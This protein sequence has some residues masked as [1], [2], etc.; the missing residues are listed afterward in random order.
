[1]STTQHCAT[2]P[3]ALET[4]IPLAQKL[5]AREARTSSDADDLVQVALF[6]YHRAAER[7]VARRIRLDRPWAFAKTT[8]VR[9]MRLYYQQQGW[10]DMLAS[11]S[12][13]DMHISTAGQHHHD[14]FDALHEYFA[15]VERECGTLARDIA[16]QLVA[17][18]GDTAGAILKTAAHKRRGRSAVRGVKFTLR[19]SQR[20]IR[21]AMGIPPKRWQRELASLREFTRTWLAA[22]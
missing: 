21:D 15:A 19:I 2:P 9:A 13:D 5:A 20:A 18:H 8:M 6:A 14:G 4:V 17:P 10:Y 7:Y 1:M 3:L 22:A 16:A 12:V 11:E